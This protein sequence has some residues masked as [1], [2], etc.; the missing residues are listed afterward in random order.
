V[1]KL[2]IPACQALHWIRKKEEKHNLKTVTFNDSD[3]VKHLEMAIKYGYP[4][5]FQDIDDYIDPIIDNVL[6]KNIKGEC[7][8]Y[9]ALFYCLYC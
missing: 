4:I 1:Y 9:Q 6:E 8:F 2:T 7:F 5:L 3:F